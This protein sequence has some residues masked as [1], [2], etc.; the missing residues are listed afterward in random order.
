MTSQNYVI[1]YS[2]EKWRRVLDQQLKSN[3]GPIDTAKFDLNE[4][5]YNGQI[6]QFGSGHFT[7]K[8]F[9]SYN[10]QNSVISNTFPNFSIQIVLNIN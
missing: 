1:R 6:I 5:G 9:L 2:R 7:K 3:S 4:L 8:T 10:E